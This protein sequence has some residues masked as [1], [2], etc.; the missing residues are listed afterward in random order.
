[1]ASQF[2]GMDSDDST[3]GSDDCGEKEPPCEVAASVK[4]NNVGAHSNIDMKEDAAASKPAATAKA[5]AAP[6][7]SKRVTAS[8][9]PLQELEANPE[10]VE[11]LLE[12]CE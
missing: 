10:F 6:A 9:M 12:T 8:P 4:D 3:Q 2:D 1:M 11:V 7:P 5:A